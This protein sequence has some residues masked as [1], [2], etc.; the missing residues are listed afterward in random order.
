MRSIFYIVLFLTAIILFG[1]SPS[2]IEGS[3]QADE[4]Q[5]PLAK[6]DFYQMYDKIF[7]PS[8]AV[9]GCHDGS[10]E[11]NFTT[12]QSSYST[13]VWHP[14]IKNDKEGSYEYRV[15]PGD[16]SLSVLHKR[17]TD[18]CFVDVNDRM[19][20]YDKEGLS[21][22]QLDLISKWILEGAK[23]ILGNTPASNCYLPL[24]GNLEILIRPKEGEEKVVD[25]A[26]MNQLNE[27]LFLAIEE[28]AQ[29]LVFRIPFV[30][31]PHLCLPV[32]SMTFEL[33][34]FED[35]QRTKRSPQLR[36]AMHIEGE[37]LLA[38]LPIG[39]LKSQVPYY[40]QLSV[41][42]NGRSWQ[43]SGRVQGGVFDHTWALKLTK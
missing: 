5:S 10:F 8:C 41:N 6:S 18:C 20:F 28:A 32:D 27:P 43:Y 33:L 3:S 14:V 11:P 19:P 37:L 13:L 36:K 30:E 2:P 25:Q 1:L 42:A 35:V 22:A 4:T 9:A 31:R 24:L 23:D 16:T 34:A 39:E 7:K 17:V 29:T 12:I 38:E 21:K 40:W 15:V 26:I